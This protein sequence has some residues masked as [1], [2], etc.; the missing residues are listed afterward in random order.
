MND[1]SLLQI[2][3]RHKTHFS[4]Q[5]IYIQSNKEFFIGHEWNIYYI[6]CIIISTV[7]S[8]RGKEQKMS[9]SEFYGLNLPTMIVA[10]YISAAVA[11]QYPLLLW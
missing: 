11:A 1:V 2:H 10:E 3:V 6:C 9:S 4:Q 8:F 7:S 5:K